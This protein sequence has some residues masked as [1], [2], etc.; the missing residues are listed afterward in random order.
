MKTKFH[1]YLALF[2]VLA[3]MTFSGCIVPEAESK[4]FTAA[5]VT[6]TLTEEFTEQSNNQ[7][8]AVWASTT[9]IVSVIKED[10]EM[11]QTAGLSID[12]PITEYAQLVI[13]NN[14]LTA[15]VNE[16]GDTAYF[17]FELERVGKMMRYYAVTYR[18]DDAFWLIQ[19]GAEADTFDEHMINFKTYVK[20]I[21]FAE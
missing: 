5:G 12:M 7:Q 14:Q 6:I 4:D 17:T 18:T 1:K 15:T 21:T 13:D 16:D 9:E 10:F 8:T 2:M 19:F 11:L 20:S 3:V